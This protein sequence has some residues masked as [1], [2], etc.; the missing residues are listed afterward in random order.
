[1]VGNVIEWVADWVPRSDD[2]SQV[3]GGSVGWEHGNG[4]DGNGYQCLL[5]ASKTG[6]PGALWRGGGISDGAG[7]GVFA[8]SG[9]NSPNA[10]TFDFGFRA[11]R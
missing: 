10:T 9:L 4:F 7:S 1:M 11:V 8:I 6:D 5:G 3:C 2:T